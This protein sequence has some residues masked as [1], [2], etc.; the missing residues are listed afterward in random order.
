[1]QFFRFGIRLTI[2]FFIAGTAILVLFYFNPTTR[3]ALIAYQFTIIGIVANW[4]YV[5][6]LLFNFLRVK[7]N[8]INLMKTL[9]VMAI[10]IPVGILY[11]YIMVWLL[12]YARITFQ[13]N[14]GEKIPL[15]KIEGCEE[16][17]LTDLENES[18]KSTW[19]KIPGDCSINILYEVNGETKTETVL[20]YVT[21]GQGVKML[22]EIGG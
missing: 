16:K 9:G 20:G 8:T 19:I 15:L 5:I 3:I 17:M 18:S 22:Y 4:I 21:P 12:G 1:M 13:N 2:S 7:I 14:T 10:N 11:S 6:V